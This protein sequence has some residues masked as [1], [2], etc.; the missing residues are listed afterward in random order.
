[1]TN[2]ATTRR[3]GAVGAGAI[4]I[5]FA[6]SQVA[7]AHHCFKEEW[8]AAAHR[9][10]SGN[11]SP[12]MPVS[13]L[14][15]MFVLTPEQAEVCGFVADDAVEEWMDYRGLDQEPLIHLKATIGSGAYY[16][17]GKAP[18]P[19]GYLEDPDFIMIETLIAEALVA[20]NCPMPPAEG[21]D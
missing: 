13:D 1:M 6:T 3:L 2:H 9:N 19:I 8:A 12:W 20:N 14:A 10:Q 11:S 4:A 5:L 15:A 17:K 16:N 21:D 7:G 18:K